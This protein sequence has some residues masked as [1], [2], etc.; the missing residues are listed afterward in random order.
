MLIAPRSCRRGR[1]MQSVTGRRGAP[2]WANA[3][4][5]SGKPVSLQVA[6]SRASTTQVRRRTVERYAER[7]AGEAFLDVW[8]RLLAKAGKS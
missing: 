5:G 3:F 2:A 8:D 4:P 6:T 1:K 7:V